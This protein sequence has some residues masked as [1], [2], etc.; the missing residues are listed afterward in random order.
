M[1]KHYLYLSAL[2]I[3]NLAIITTPFII[4]LIAEIIIGILAIKYKNYWL[5]AVLSVTG[6]ISYLIGNLIPSVTFYN[7]SFLIN[8]NNLVIAMIIIP[9]PLVINSL[10]IWLG[11]Q[12]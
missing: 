12:D 7:G 2:I 9:V 10:F 5:T 3:A 4:T 11:Q 8:K 1:N 6:L